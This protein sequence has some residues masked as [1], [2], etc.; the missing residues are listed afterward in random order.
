MKVLEALQFLDGPIPSVDGQPAASDG[1][2]TE[3]VRADDRRVARMI[4]I[5][6]IGSPKHRWSFQSVCVFLNDMSA[7]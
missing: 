5:Y 2:C 6:L 7:D 3:K 1:F 4:E